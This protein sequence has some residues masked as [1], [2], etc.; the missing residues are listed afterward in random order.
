MYIYI[1]GYV[2]RIVFYTILNPKPLNP[3]TSKTGFVSTFSFLTLTARED[4]SR[5]PA[6]NLRKMAAVG[7][8]FEGLGLGS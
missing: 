8:T 2:L 4:R 3:Q 7:P 6:P 1:C 5:Q